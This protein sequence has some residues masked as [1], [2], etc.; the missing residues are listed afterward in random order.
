MFNVIFLN[1]YLTAFCQNV[2]AEQAN[3]SKQRREVKFH[4][5]HQSWQHSK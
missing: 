3:Q 1:G 4:S 2:Q 5:Y